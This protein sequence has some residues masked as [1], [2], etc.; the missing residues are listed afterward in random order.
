MEKY[1]H[2]LYLHIL[3]SYNDRLNSQAF[4]EA[5]LYNVFKMTLDA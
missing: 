5:F 3:R 2:L 1:T 4:T